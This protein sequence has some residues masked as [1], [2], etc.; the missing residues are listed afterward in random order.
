[1]PLS[2]PHTVTIAIW[3][4]FL[5]GAWNA[6]RALSLG[7]QLELF[8]A[9]E[10]SPD[11][12][13]RLIVAL[14]WMALFWGAT[15]AIRLRRPGTGR[16]VPIL[17]ALYG[18]YELGLL[19]FFVHAPVARSAWLVNTLFYLACLLFLAWALNRP[20]ARNYFR[21]DNGGDG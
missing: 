10:I 8:L 14:V 7:R 4:V 16:S 19:S 1:M 20:A 17:M 11:P 2:R 6:G 15:I 12:R 9:W 18:L 21:E 3:G 5:I 13:L